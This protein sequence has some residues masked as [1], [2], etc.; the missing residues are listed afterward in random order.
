MQQPDAKGRERRFYIFKFLRHRFQTFAAG[1]LHAGI[2][3]ISLPPGGKLFADEFPN[4]RQFVGGADK[5]FD[6]TAAGG[7][8]VNH[9]NIEVAVKRQAEGAGNR[10]CR[11]HEQV[12]I[13]ALAHELFALGHAKLV[14]LINDDQ[15]QLRQI[16]TGREQGVSAN[17]QSRGSRVEGRRPERLLALDSRLSTLDRLA[18]AGL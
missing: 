16:K 17:V 15:A 9:R 1:F 2:N 4:L 7:Q 8:L 14:L 18:T 3:D 6:P 10:R 12:W 13:T 11:H 5:R